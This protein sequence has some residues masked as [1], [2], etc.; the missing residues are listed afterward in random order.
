MH[1]DEA[2]KS[3]AFGAKRRLLTVLADTH[4]KDVDVIS[5]IEAVLEFVPISGYSLVSKSMP[6]PI[7]ALVDL[8]VMTYPVYKAMSQAIRTFFG[9]KLQNCSK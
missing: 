7:A 4:R 8:D 6:I 2:N 1:A 3:V 9:T 5:G